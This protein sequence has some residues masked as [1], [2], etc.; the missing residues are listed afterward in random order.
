MK[1]TVNDENIE[2]ISLSNDEVLH[3]IGKVADFEIAP[4]GSNI[5]L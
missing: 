4:C 3:R 2:C 5:K 1:G